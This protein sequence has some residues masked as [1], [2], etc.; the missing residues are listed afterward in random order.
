MSVSGYFGGNG[1]FKQEKKEVMTEM[2]MGA[3]DLEQEAKEEKKARKPRKAKSVD[4]E[5]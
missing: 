4:E 1:A 5:V 2:R 3:I